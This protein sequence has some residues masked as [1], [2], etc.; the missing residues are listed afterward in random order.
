MKKARFEE[1]LSSVK[2][3]TE[4]ARGRVHP[5][6]HCCCARSATIR[7]TSLER[8]PELPNLNSVSGKSG[9]PIGRAMTEIDPER[10]VRFPDSGPC[11][12]K[13]RTVAQPKLSALTVK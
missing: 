5:R 1:L 10:S 9:R 11:G 8:Y 3:A 4:I 6:G 13:K 7:S 2:Q 12:E